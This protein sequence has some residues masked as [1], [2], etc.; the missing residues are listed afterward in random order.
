MSRSTEHVRRDPTALLR[1]ARNGEEEIASVYGF[2]QDSIQAQ[3]VSLWPA[4]AEKVDVALK[5]PASAN[6]RRS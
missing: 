3:A 2:L 1:A 5:A 6:S 4:M